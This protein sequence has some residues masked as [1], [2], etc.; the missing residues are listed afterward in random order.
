MENSSIT[1]SFRLPYG[2]GS[3]ILWEKKEKIQ[4]PPFFLW[5]LFKRTHLCFSFC[6]DFFSPN[7]EQKVAIVSEKRTNKRT[8]Y[9]FTPQYMYVASILPGGW[10]VIQDGGSSLIRKLD[11]NGFI[12]IISNFFNYKNQQTSKITHSLTNN[13]LS[14]FCFR[15]TNNYF[16]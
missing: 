5:R 4:M 12:S 2:V 1:S 7:N 16:Q 8:I 13:C 9:V 14:S 3:K 6:L 15:S 11:N 10:K